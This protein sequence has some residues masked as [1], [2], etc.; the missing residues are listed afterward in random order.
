MRL[1]LIIAPLPHNYVSSDNFINQCG[2]SG[3]IMVRKL[4]AI[5]GMK[6]VSKTLKKG[7]RVITTEAVPSGMRLEAALKAA[8][9]VNG[10]AIV[11]AHIQKLVT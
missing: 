4:K 1:Y 7:D 8:S 10:R 11:L 3:I 6:G 9:R 2:S 5:S